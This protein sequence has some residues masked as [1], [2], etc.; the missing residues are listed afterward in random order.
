MDSAPLVLIAALELEVQPILQ[1]FRRVSKNFPKR[2]EGKIAH[3]Q[4]VFFISGI[5]F[6]AARD[7]AIASLKE[8]PKGVISIGF[9]GGLN[10]SFSTGNLFMPNQI[11]HEKGQSIPCH[12]LFSPARLGIKSGTLYT[13]GKIISTP[14]EKFKLASLA[15]AV[16]ME[17]YAIAEIMA[18]NNIPFAGI[19]SILDTSQEA[20]PLDFSPMLANGKVQ[21]YRV[22]LNILQHP[23][24]LIPLIKLA[25][26]SQANAKTLCELS[27]EI[28][29]S[30]LPDAA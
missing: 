27:A 8:K 10:P 28:I 6:R 22:L 21:T 30:Y 9:A 5:G 18:E 3:H 26:R 25:R 24:K 1:G 20:M 2:Y 15:D 16:D 13:S 23:Q 11:R 4:A 19:R 12:G 14:A 7:S 29:S 17:S